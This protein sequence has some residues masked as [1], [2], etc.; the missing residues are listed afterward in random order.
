MGFSP[1]APIIIAVGRPPHDAR[2][3][4]NNIFQLALYRT[5]AKLIICLQN[6]TVLMNTDAFSLVLAPR[7]WLPDFGFQILA[8]KSWTPDPGYQILATRSW[9]PGLGYEMHQILATRS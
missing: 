2:Y 6:R 4:H 3:S 8:I 1:K 7:S 9:L 5:N